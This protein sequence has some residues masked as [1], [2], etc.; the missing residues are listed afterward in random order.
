MCRGFGDLR[1]IA[2]QDRRAALG[3][4]HRVDRI[5]EHQDPIGDAECERTARAA[6][7]DHDGD[8]RALEARHHLQRLRDRLGLATLLGAEP[9]IRA[10]RVD[11]ANDRALESRREPH[12]A[13][14]FAI[15]LGARH[16][17]VAM[18]VVLRVAALLVA[19]HEHF[20]FIELRDA[21]DDR[22]IVAEAAIAVELDEVVHQQADVIHHVRPRRMPRELDFLLRRQIGE[23]FFLELL[24]LL[25]EPP[26]LRG[27]VDGLGRQVPQVGNLLFEIDDRPLELEDHAVGYRRRFGRRHGYGLA[28]YRPTSSRS[29]A[30]GLGCQ[31]I[32]VSER[33]QDTCLRA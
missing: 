19:E 15:A 3:R 14:R 10:R 7:A 1:R 22:R 11:E 9:G 27:E 12:E 24:R 4:D 16:A 5:L 13:R 6:L 23:D 32:V 21:A 26:D 25:L 18:D 2:P 30:A 20:P 29:T 31:V 8:H 28:R 17:E 33:Y